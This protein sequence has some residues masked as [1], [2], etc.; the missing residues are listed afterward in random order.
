[1]T[2]C[3]EVDYYRVMP[4]CV[5]MGQAVGIAA[6]LCVKENVLPRNLEVKKIQQILIDQSSRPM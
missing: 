1:M 2:N 4:I 6:A 3:I 5:N